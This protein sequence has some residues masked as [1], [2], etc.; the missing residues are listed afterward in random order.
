MIKIPFAE[1][2]SMGLKVCVFFLAV[3]TSGVILGFIIALVQIISQKR[4]IISYR[5]KIKKIQLELDTLR[6]QSIDDNLV[7]EDE[8]EENKDSNIIL[9]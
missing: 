5:S 2:D 7:L 8:S 4:E 9:E 1:N 6:N 3:L